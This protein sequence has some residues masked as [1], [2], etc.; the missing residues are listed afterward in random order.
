MKKREYF[1]KGHI[2]RRTKMKSINGRFI[3]QVDDIPIEI[4]NEKTTL[5][6]VREYIDSG[7]NFED[8]VSDRRLEIIEKIN[9]ALGIIEDISIKEG[10]HRIRIDIKTKQ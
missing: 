5:K 10:H 7:M 9:E 3:Y 6:A 2:I 8:T 1:Y 4:G